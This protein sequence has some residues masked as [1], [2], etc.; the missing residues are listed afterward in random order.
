[1]AYTVYVLFFF[2]YPWFP[3]LPT[4]LVVDFQLSILNV[5]FQYF[6]LDVSSVIWLH[7]VHSLDSLIPFKRLLGALFSKVLYI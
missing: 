2:L 7:L 5:H 3:P 6:F 1:M 4:D